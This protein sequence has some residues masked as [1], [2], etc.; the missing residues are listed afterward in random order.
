MVCRTGRRASADSTTPATIRAAPAIHPS[1]LTLLAQTPLGRPTPQDRQLEQPRLRGRPL[2]V[3][4][5]IQRGA[6][7]AAA[8][9]GF[10]VPVLRR[11]ATPILGR[12][13][14]RSTGR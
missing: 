11:R 5:E 14:Q 9:T 13:M 1:L 12:K 2:L 4:L 7:R 6:L 3:E 8:S 10:S